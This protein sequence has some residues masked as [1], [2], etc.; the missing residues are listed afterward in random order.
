[1]AGRD[2]EETVKWQGP[3][4][5]MQRLE[6]VDNGGFARAEYNEAAV[7]RV[8]LS[9]SEWRLY[10]GLRSY[11]FRGSDWRSVTDCFPIPRTGG[12][13]PQ[14]DAQ[15][16][17]KTGSVLGQAPRIGVSLSFISGPAITWRN[18]PNGAIC[19]SPSLLRPTVTL[20]S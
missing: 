19:F 1:M 14:R 18:L 10:G 13:D 3:L 2:P 8:D 11:S 4:S 16:G 6:S 9:L 15:T 5:V 12:C 17:Q 7:G 20:S